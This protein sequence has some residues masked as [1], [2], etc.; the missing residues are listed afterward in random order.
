MLLCL[1]CLLTRIASVEDGLKE[2]KDT[3]QIIQLVQ[4]K[5]PLGRINI[6]MGNHS[7]V[8]VL[9]ALGS[10]VGVVFHNYTSHLCDRIWAEF[11]SFST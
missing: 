10:H 3:L 9:Y 1:F 5:T 4:G 11:Q 7:G 8:A 2:L 6:R